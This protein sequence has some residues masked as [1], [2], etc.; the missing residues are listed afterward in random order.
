MK[1][2]EKF[3]LGLAVSLL[4]SLPCF[5]EGGSVTL[6]ASEFQTLKIALQTADEQLTKSENEIVS[7]K[8]RLKES[9]ELVTNLQIKSENLLSL[10]NEQEK[11]LGTLTMQLDTALTSLNKLKKET[12]QNNVILIIIGA[13]GIVLGGSLVFLLIGG[14]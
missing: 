5:A 2:L 12:Q 13:V 4:L 8:E 9:Q 6:T 14:R 10:L 3:F 1:R 7:L 11:D